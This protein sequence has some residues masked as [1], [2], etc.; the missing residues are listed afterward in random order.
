MLCDALLRSLHPASIKIRRIQGELR[1][2]EQDGIPLPR[3]AEWV[4]HVFTCREEILMA[5][6]L[7]PFQEACCG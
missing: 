6:L 1:R 3:M 5:N 7:V 4:F 2:A